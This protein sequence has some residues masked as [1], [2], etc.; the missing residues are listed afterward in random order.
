MKPILN[1]C[2]EELKQGS[3]RIDYVLG[4]LETL[5]ETQYPVMSIS[6]SPPIP[7]HLVAPGYVTSSSGMVGTID[8]EATSLDAQAR[9]AMES[10]RKMEASGQITKE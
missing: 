1:R 6:Q 8:V 2:I 7:A 5:L 10:I 3:P 9:A 4:M